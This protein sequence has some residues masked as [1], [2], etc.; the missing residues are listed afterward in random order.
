MHDDVAIDTDRFRERF[1]A[2]AE[3]GATDAGGLHRLALSDADRRA[4]DRFVEDLR[5][6][7][8]DVR[9]D[10][11]GN[12]F[13]RY[14][15]G[16]PDAAPVLVGSHLDSQPYG[17][18]FDGQL[19]VLTALEAVQ[20]I[21]ESPVEPDRPV[22]VVNWTNEEGTRFQPSM[23]GSSG[24]VGYEPVEELLDATDRDG[25]SVREELERIG[26]DGDAPC[27][28]PEAGVHSF[29][30][31]HVE[32]GP[33]LDDEG[34]PVA[35]VDGVYGLSWLRVTVDGEAN[36]AGPTPMHD[37][38]DALAAATDAIRE[39]NR[40]PQQLS[41][42]AVATVGELAVEPNSINVIPARAEF[43][44][45]LRS[46]DDDAVDRGVERVEAEVAAA[47]D[48]HGADYEVERVSRHHSL[49]FSDRVRDAADRGVAAAGVD[50]R[51]L[52]SGAGHDAQHLQTLTDAGMLFVPSVD[53]YTHTEA[54]YTEWADCV[55]GARAFA[56]TALE[57]AT[58]N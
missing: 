23:M 51:H 17:G 44:V 13:G 1:E 24:Y 19:G 30:E 36:H 29:L 33:V 21:A 45:D 58:E 53:G 25:V 20:A 11:L 16:D 5:D 18:R 47:C 7:G 9:I 3:F 15:A 57:L 49:S 52:V 43:T 27:E 12:V 6:A 42:D 22:E 31:L 37:R 41:A 46:Y 32:Q 48:R 28:P 38:S 40:L 2:Y 10:E 35:I 14:E 34:V 55:A 8:L 39:V 56:H 4:R 26:Y 50:A 54:E